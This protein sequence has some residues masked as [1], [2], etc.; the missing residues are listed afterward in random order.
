MAA[1]KDNKDYWRDKYL[2][3]LEKHTRLGE[4]ILKALENIEPKKKSRCGKAI[5]S[6]RGK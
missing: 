4:A 3:L 2:A 6:S 1:I 5:S